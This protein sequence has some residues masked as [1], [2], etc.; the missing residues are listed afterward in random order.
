M[1]EL[2]ADAVPTGRLLDVDR[3]PLDYRTA[4]TLRQWFPEKGVRAL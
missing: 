1:L 2:D 3:T 4:R